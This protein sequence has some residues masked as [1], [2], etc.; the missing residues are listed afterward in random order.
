MQT[1]AEIEKLHDSR[2]DIQSRHRIDRWYGVEGSVRDRVIDE[3]RDGR[4]KVVYHTPTS[5]HVGIDV[6]C[7]SM[8]LS[9]T[10]VILLSKVYAI[11][12]IIIMLLSEISLNTIPL[13]K[14][15]GT[16]DPQTRLISTVSVVPA[17]FEAC[18]RSHFF[19]SWQ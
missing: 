7:V 19:R 3:F 4:A 1:A 11:G 10:Y 9:T 8:V 16:A 17:D 2:E 13:S 18:R 15:R 6:S 5:S 12:L 14:R